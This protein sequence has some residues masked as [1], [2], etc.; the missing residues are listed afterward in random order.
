MTNYGAMIKKNRK[1]G[2][3]TKIAPNPA[4]TEGLEYQPQPAKMGAPIKDIPL[5]ILNTAL[6]FNANLNQ[7]QLLLENKGIR[8]HIDTINNFCKR[9]FGMTFSE[10]REKRFDHTKLLLVQKA[11]KM[12]LEDGNVALLIFC[13]K[14]I[15]GWRDNLQKDQ[16]VNINI[17][18]LQQLQ[19]LPREKVI[20]LG[21]EAIKYLEEHAPKNLLPNQPGSETPSET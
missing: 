6:H 5:D 16:P 17:T 8:V 20:E 7:V 11:I 3:K 13:L 14:N 15:C 18:Q 12:A 19:Q 21:R 10:Y 9:T 2:P 1:P 4:D